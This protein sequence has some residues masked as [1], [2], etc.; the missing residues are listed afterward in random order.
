MNKGLNI[1]IIDDDLDDQVLMQQAFEST[2]SPVQVRFATRSDEALQWLGRCAD[3]EKPDI[4]VS[5]YNMPMMNGEEFLKR[6]QADE[7]YRD[8]PKVIV[9][10]AASPSIIEA[11]VSH[12]ASKYLIKPSDFEE[13]IKL[14]REIIALSDR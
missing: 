10:T 5:D 3:V 7:R 8:T 14:A 1:F 13:L 6:L 2:G 4:I 11:C 12:G 9:S